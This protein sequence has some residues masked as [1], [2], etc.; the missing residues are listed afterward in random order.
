MQEARL[1][2]KYGGLKWLNPDKNL[3]FTARTEVMI[4]EK[5]RGDNQYHVFGVA[6]GYD[7]DVERE[8]QPGLWD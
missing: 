8:K 6:G 3:V 1:L 2:R 5:K 7:L 4:F